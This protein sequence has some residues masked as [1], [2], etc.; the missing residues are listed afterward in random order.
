MRHKNK[1]WTPEENERLKAFVSK[2]GSVVGAAG[3]FKCTMTCVRAQ[4]RKLGAPFPTVREVKKRL[5]S[6]EKKP[7]L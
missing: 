5:A 7:S 1:L 6:Y 3:A 2:G 4:A